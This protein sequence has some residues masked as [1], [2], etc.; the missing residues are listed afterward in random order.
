MSNRKGHFGPNDRNNQTGERG[1]PSK[2][3]PNV[4]VRP[5]QNGPFHL[6]YQ[7]KIS[8]FWVEWKAPQRNSL[9][10]GFQK[11]KKRTLYGCEIFKFKIG[12]LRSDEAMAAKPSLKR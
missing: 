1:P 11:K 8:K 10:L 4:P 9:I 2:L 3:V 5:N 12:T 7:P 6:M